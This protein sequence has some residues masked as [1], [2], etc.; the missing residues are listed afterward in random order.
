MEEGR[1]LGPRG[2]RLAQL[3]KDNSQISLNALEGSFLKFSSNEAVVTYDESLAAA[4]YIRDTYGVSDIHRLLERTAQGGT[5]EQAMQDILHVDY[6][7]FERELGDYLGSK[8]G[9]Q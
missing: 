9:A 1:S 8:Y 3:Y 6:G 2:H 4:M 7:R 5:F